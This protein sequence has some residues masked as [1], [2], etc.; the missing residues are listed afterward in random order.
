MMR[1]LF[2]TKETFRDTV[3]FDRDQFVS[4][5]LEA[6]GYAPAH[7][8]LSDGKNGALIWE[9][10]QSNA[11]RGIALWHGELLGRALQ[12][13]LS[14]Q[15]IEGTSEDYEFVNELAGDQNQALPAAGQAAEPVTHSD[16]STGAAD[17]N[18]VPAPQPP[19]EAAEPPKDDKPKKKHKGWLSR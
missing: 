16:A 13:T 11:S 6:Q 10:M 2:G 3:R 8:T 17:I 15:P 18:V 9:A 5:R 19:S 4:A 14:L 12:G 7:Y 1:A